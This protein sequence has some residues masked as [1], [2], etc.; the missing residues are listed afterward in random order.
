VSVIVPSRVSF[1]LLGRSYLAF[2][3]AP[4]QPFGD[5]LSELDSRMLR[6]P[7]FFTNRPLILDLSACAAGR[8]ELSDLIEGI[9]ARG[10]RL[11][12][13]EGV[14]A[15]WLPSRLAPLPGTSLPVGMFGP[16]DDERPR[17]SR[18]RQD[19]PVPSTTRTPAKGECAT[20][21]VEEPVR[22]GQ[23]LMFPAGDVTIVGSV[24]SGAEIVAG[25]SIHVYGT[26]RG[27]A[28]AGVSG[29]TKARIFC[30]KFDAEIL[31]IDGLYKTADDFDPALRGAQV[32]A[33]LERDVLSIEALN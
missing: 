19:S 15:D 1:R 7:N 16:Q 17:P 8:T 29:N 20:L 28:F 27:R 2:V 12:A 32:Q 6:S 13:V 23:T 14:P 30:N 18:Q 31:V 5:W 11:V 3:L 26:L 21:L 25:G 33:R 24:A 4:D 10:L 9:E 22:S